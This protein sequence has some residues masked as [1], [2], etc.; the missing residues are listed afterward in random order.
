M[1]IY[2]SVNLPPELENL[3]RDERL[4]LTRVARDAVAV[5][6]FRRGV[7]NHVQLGG[8]LGLDRFET[9]ALLKQ[10]KVSEHALTHSDVDA[11]VGSINDLVGPPR[12]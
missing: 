3:L 5:D 4:D 9:D 8:V 12:P 10:H 2:V 7:L 6:L 11:D 1:D